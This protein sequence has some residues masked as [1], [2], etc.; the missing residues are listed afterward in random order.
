MS[1][2]G[3]LEKL[4]RMY[5]CGVNDGESTGNQYMLDIVVMV[6]HAQYGFGAK[7][8][9]DF[10]TRVRDAFDEYYPALV[11]IKKNK[12]CDVLRSHMDEIL[13]EA[14]AGASELPE[15]KTLRGLRYN[16]VP[17]EKR[18]PHLKEVTYK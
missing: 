16:F 18:Y 10:V 8:M 6:L 4:D 17:F 2:S 9:C 14:L 1:K 11:A 5:V 7:R 15:E 3:Y 12:E 13:A